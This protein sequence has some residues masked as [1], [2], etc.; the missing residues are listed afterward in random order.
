VLKATATFDRNPIR[1]AG[2][3]IGNTLTSTPKPEATPKPDDKPTGL[4]G[5]LKTLFSGWSTREEKETKQEPVLFESI[6]PEATPRMTQPPTPTP[7]PTPTP[8]PTPSEREN[9]AND[10]IAF[11]KGVI[12]KPY[13]NSGR[14]GTKGYDCSGLVIAMCKE[15]ESEL[16]FDNVHIKATTK[17]GMSQSFL[18]N[19]EYGEP[20]YT[21]QDGGSITEL[22]AGDL[23]FSAKQSNLKLDS[24]VSIAT[25]EMIYDSSTGEYWPQV[26]EASS[27]AGKVTSIYPAFNKLDNEGY[28][29]RSHTN[30]IITYVI[31]PNYDWEENP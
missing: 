24:H 30:Q 3:S 15:I 9:L 31:R 25:G 26:I 12:G 13:S 18:D 21:Y 23:V 10:G 8:V 29:S 14:Y 4:F 5:W 20:I 6:A 2:S 27:V 16:P 28:Y 11:A 17:Y 22:Q 19:P 7:T 1:R